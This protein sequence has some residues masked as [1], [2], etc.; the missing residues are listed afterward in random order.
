[1]E[2]KIPN[3]FA[4]PISKDLKNGQELYYG[5]SIS[6]GD[7]NADTKSVMKKINDIFNA[8][9]FI[10]KRRVR[11]N[12]NDNVLEKVIVGRT[13]HSLLTMENESILISSILDIERID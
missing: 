7:R 3:V 4:N 2:K 12:T 9:N 5:N 1:M 6:K 8:R 13:E 10:Y 11:I